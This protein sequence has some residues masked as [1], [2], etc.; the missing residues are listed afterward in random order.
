[1][2]K[3]ICM[4]SR[5]SVGVTFMLWSY[6]WLSG[7]DKHYFSKQNAWVPLVSDPNTS[8]NAHHF[9]KNIAGSLQTI[10]DEIN[11]YHQMEQTDP[12]ALYAGYFPKEKTDAEQSNK[13]YANIVNHLLES[14]I[15]TVIVIESTQDSYYL[16]KNRSIDPTSPASEI[17][18]DTYKSYLQDNVENFMSSYFSNNLQMTEQNIWDIREILALNFTHLV[19]FGNYASFINFRL[20]HFY[21][22]SR[23]LWYD[24]EQT[25]RRLFH[26]LQQPIDDSRLDNWRFVYRKWQQVHFDILRFGWLLPH[27]IEAVVQGYDYDLGSLQL[28]LAREAIIQGHLLKN[29]NL[30][31]KT[32]GLDRFPNNT[33]ELHSLIEPNTLHLM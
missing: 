29:Y 14:G 19:S 10:S 15:P 23:E 33:R 24:G 16:V 28:D 21:L 5:F 4:T 32:F 8:I 25:M 1:M 3:A 27:I 13:E 11:K 17:T 22:D 18:K 30:N 20:P 12:I 31:L 26:W 2:S 9:Q 7:V 6:Y